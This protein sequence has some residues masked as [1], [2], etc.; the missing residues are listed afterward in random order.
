MKRKI[1]ANNIQS[2]RKNN[3]EDFHF[4]IINKRVVFCGVLLNGTRLW[5]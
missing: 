3:Y 5:V 4:Q 2:F 1:S